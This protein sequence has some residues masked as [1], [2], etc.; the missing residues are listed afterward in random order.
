PDPEH[1]EFVVLEMN[2]CVI[3]RFEAHEY[4]Q[5]R[6]M[7]VERITYWIR[8]APK[9]EKI[10]SHRKHLAF[11]RLLREMRRL[12][13][14]VARQPALADAERVSQRARQ[15]GDRLNLQ[16]A[17]LNRT[18]E[19]SRAKHTRYAV[20]EPRR[21]QQVLQ[22]NRQRIEEAR[23]QLKDLQRQQADCALQ[24]NEL[25][26]TEADLAR[27]VE[28]QK[29]QREL[30]AKI[31]GRKEQIGTL[32]AEVA[33]AERQAAAAQARARELALEIGEL[34]Q[35]KGT[36][37]EERHKLS[38]VLS[39]A[40][41]QRELR[42]IH[43]R[44][45]KRLTQALSVLAFALVGIPLGIVASR[46]SV[47]VAFG[48]SFAI[49]LLIFYPFLILGQVGAEEGILPVVPAMWAGNVFTFLIGAFL[50]AK[51]MRR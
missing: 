31:E 33:D 22:E 13:R 39:L 2:D 37:L 38:R 42:A 28:L 32:S 17:E 10:L 15:K 23:Q 7:S 35:H 41:D 30:L 49:V 19:A 36:L 20:L 34:R 21:H 26:E 1:G 44:I 24:L 29:L 47:M 14:S 4:D 16:I 27:M 9:M 40:D 45:H 25:Q 46:R 43:I 51:V 48:I 3:T 5:P 6:T 50:M 11:P 8:V 12:R 18:L